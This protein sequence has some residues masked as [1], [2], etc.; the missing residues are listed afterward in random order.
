[1][2][3]KHMRRP[4]VEATTGLATSTIYELMNR[5]GPDGKPAFPRPFKLSPR[6]V[7]WRERDI[8]A[9]LEARMRE[10]AGNRKAREAAPC[11]A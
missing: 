4:E 6:R 10:P 9:W 3:E 1:M 8:A 5:E 7:A 2:P 11:P